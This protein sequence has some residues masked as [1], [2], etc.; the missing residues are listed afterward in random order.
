M[1]TLTRSL[2]QSLHA[3]QQVILIEPDPDTLWRV[4]VELSYFTRDETESLG[5][6]LV[7]TMPHGEKRAH[8]S[9]RMA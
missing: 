3:T 6:G 7:R 2:N 1:R 8:S 9:V 4:L 5:G